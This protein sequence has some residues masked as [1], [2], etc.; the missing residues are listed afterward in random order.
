M[1]CFARTLA[2]LL[3]STSAVSARLVRGLEYRR[4]QAPQAAH[5]RT[6][7]REEPPD[8]VM[9]TQSAT[10][11][12]PGG[13]ETHH[14]PP[15]LVLA[16]HET[17]V[18]QGE[19]KEL[20]GAAHSKRLQGKLAALR[21]M[22]NCGTNATANA[23]GNATAYTFREALKQAIG[24][25]ALK[26]NT[27]AAAPPTVLKNPDA[28]EYPF[29]PLLDVDY[30]LDADNYLDDYDHAY[31]IPQRLA[32][33]YLPDTTTTTTVTTTTVTTTSTSSTSSTSTTPA[34][35]TTI[36]R[37]T[38]RTTST[39]TV[40]TT[41]VTT[42]TVTTTT[43]I[44]PVSFQSCTTRRDPRVERRLQF[45]RYSHPAPAGTKCIFGVVPEDERSHCIQDG[46]KFGSFGWCYTLQ[47]RSQWGSCSENCP[48]EG[49]TEVLAHRIDKLT[50]TVR[51]ALAKIGASKCVREAVS[52]T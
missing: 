41:T 27:T 5:G 14:A 31:D 13:G 45:L 49:S 40:T 26:Y 32:E 28:P 44:P 20:R 37:T 29:D 2:L 1:S 4:L 39:T 24:A 36:L 35:V 6:N 48:L 23:T 50:K 18:N 10:A 30:I 34:P 19:G 46:G 43:P 12:H 17:T 22:V 7:A 11:V 51:T 38:T 8:L 25:T 9:L 16:Q 42:T 15:D 52:S 3:A 21:W 47:D 33:R